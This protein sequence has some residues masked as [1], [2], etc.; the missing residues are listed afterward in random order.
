MGDLYINGIKLN[1][2]VTFKE[3]DPKS[4]QSVAK[5]GKLIAF[6][7]SGT[8]WVEVMRSKTVSS[9]TGPKI[10]LYREI[11]QLKFH[12]IRPVGDISQNEDVFD[13]DEGDR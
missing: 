8:V 12:E 2:R 13:P 5:Y 6:S 9:L 10:K 7:E 11:V 1:D 3:F 4:E